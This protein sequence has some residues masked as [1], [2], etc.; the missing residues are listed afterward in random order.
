[1]ERFF[2][3]G[4]LAVLALGFYGLVRHRRAL[5]AKAERGRLRSW[6]HYE[7]YRR[8]IGG[9]SPDARHRFRDLDEQEQFRLFMEWSLQE[10]L[11]SKEY[12][13]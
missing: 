10:G 6:R 5:K 9:L 13:L 2:L 7:H 8:F 12:K 1:M 3:A 4:I 11:Q